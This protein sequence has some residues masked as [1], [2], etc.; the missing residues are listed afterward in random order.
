M[1]Q[2]LMA[3]GLYPQQPQHGQQPN[4]HNLGLLQNNQGANPGLGIIGGQA[5]PS[6]PNYA[7]NMPQGNPQRRIFMGPQ[8]NGS[9]MHPGGGGGP[10]GAATDFLKEQLQ[11]QA[12]SNFN[13][14]SLDTPAIVGAKD[15]RMGSKP[16]NKTAL[17]PGGVQ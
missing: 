9:G 16:V 13:S 4:Q 6:N 1:H 17:H 5:G 12:R 3:P 7:M 2:S 10:P 15:S 11:K 8:P 14:S